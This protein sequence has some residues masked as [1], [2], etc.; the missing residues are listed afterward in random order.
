MKTI[1]LVVNLFLV[2][3]IVCSCANDPDPEI[4]EYQPI[5]FTFQDA[6]GKDLVKE[7]V[8]PLLVY[9]GDDVFLSLS[10]D[11]Y[12]LKVIYP[13]PCM[14]P[15][16]ASREKCRKSESCW[17]LDYNTP[18]FYLDLVKE[19]DFWEM[20]FI[21]ETS[22]QCSK[23]KMLTLHVK[24][25]IFGDDQEQEIV[26]HFDGLK[27]SRILLNEKE[28]SFIQRTIDHFYM[29]KYR[30]NKPKKAVAAYTSITL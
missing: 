6:S 1:K 16:E 2:T 28:C 19:Q 7:V 21:P 20:L 12:S 8:E 4:W 10:E 3:F 30:S 9:Q 18:C 29:S 25:S 11:Y 24:S 23:A 17:A 14:D 5:I 22:N 13:Q 15:V 26:L 27:L